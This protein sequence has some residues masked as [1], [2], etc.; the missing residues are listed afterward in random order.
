M[1][2]EILYTDDLELRPLTRQD[3][4]AVHALASDEEVARYMRF[5]VHATL[6]ESEELVNEY[7]QSPKNHPFALIEKRTGAFVG[8]F[9]LKG[10]QDGCTY[11]MTA[12]SGKPYW[13]KGYNTQVLAAM[14]RY[15]RQ[16]L[17]AKAL[18]GHV[19]AGNTGSRRVLEKNGFS[20]VDTL[21]FEDLPEGL[22]V[23]RLEL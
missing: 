10:Q 13:N 1:E 22:C 5:T 20:L 18:V 11:D 6:R 23:Y 8:V 2:T 9:V 17:G 14:R 12:F 7:L 15:A 21:Y 16:F 3:V 4:F 19:V